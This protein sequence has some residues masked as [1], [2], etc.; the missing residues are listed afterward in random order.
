M[1]TRRKSPAAP[2][3]VLYCTLTLEDL[4]RR[5]DKARER[6]YL[7]TR[8]KGEGECGWA[9]V[10]VPLVLRARRRLPRRDGLE[11]ETRGK[12]ERRGNAHTGVLC[13]RCGVQQGVRSCAGHAQS[14]VPKVSR[15]VGLGSSLW[16]RAARGQAG[17]G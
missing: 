15:F 5:P 3:T 11:Q 6:Q 9:Q 16:A 1:G 2:G 12:C 4:G 7:G 13:R 14:E 17:D 8:W 10:C